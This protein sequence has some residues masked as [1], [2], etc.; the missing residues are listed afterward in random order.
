VAG[1]GTEEEAKRWIIES[2]QG[3]RYRLAVHFRERMLEREVD[4]QDVSYA[5]ANADRVERYTVG[6]PIE[7]GTCWRLFGSCLDDDRKVAIGV[8]AYLDRKRRRIILVTV[9]EVQR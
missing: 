7:G 2:F 3:S 8:E 6:A 1:P 5:I 4:F 9:F